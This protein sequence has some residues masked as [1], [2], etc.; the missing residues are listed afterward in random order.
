MTTDI[1]IGDSGEDAEPKPT[2]TRTH[3]PRTDPPA[4]AGPDT[5]LRLDVAAKLAFPD[6]GVTAASLRR[7]ATAGRLVI[8]RIAGKDFTTLHHIET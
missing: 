1:V 4:N 2:R 7:E 6:G 8:E 3:E 5:P